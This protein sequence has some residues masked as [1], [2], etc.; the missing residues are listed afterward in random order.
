M[1][2]F[3]FSISGDMSGSGS[4][5]VLSALVFANCLV[6]IA[7]VWLLD[8]NRIKS[9][10]GEPSEI[11]KKLSNKGQDHTFSEAA[12]R[13]DFWYM[14]FAAMVVIGIS[15]MFDENAEALG[16]H[17]EKQS[18]MIGETYSVYEVLG[19]VVIGSI[20]T[21]FRSKMR[22]SL[23][24]ILCILVAGLGQIPMIYPSSWT[25]S[26]PMRLAV[27]TASFAEG[28][29][30]VSLSS[31]CHEEYGTELFGVFFGTMWTFGA[32]G[33]FAFDEIYFPNLFQWYATEN[34]V[35]VTYFKTYG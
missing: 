12:I 32:A 30:L 33:L 31:F 5:I 14:S 3:Y 17:D 25:F 20:L 15:R 11:E 18:Q 24:I 2:L 10:V 28:G 27:A 22:P 1:I 23:A 7:L 6:P 4:A 13:L 21:F 34:A 29:L 26:D 19:A 35:G 8:A 9:L 16:L